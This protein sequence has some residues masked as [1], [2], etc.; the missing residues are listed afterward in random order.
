MG[1]GG[2]QKKGCTRKPKGDARS[3]G[4]ETERGFAVKNGF[5]ATVFFETGG[6]RGKAKRNNT[7]HASRITWSLDL[8]PLP[9]P[10]CFLDRENPCWG[11]S[12]LWAPTSVGVRKT[13]IGVRGGGGPPSCLHPP[14]QLPRGA[15]PQSRSS[16]VSFHPRACE[17]EKACNG[18]TVTHRLPGQRSPRLSAS[19]AGLLYNGHSHK[20]NR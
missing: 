14:P 16:S 12:P 4:N 10:R 17:S 18:R 9:T 8:P 2:Q 11:A 20:E 15:R 13:E 19:L 6:G 1:F 7:H 5:E 3:E